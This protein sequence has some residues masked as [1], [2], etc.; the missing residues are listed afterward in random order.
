MILGLVIGGVAGWFARDAVPLARKR[1]ERGRTGPPAP[2]E[3]TPVIH[4]AKGEDGW[5]V[6][7]SGDEQPLATYPTKAD[8][9]SAGR[10]QAKQDGT[11]HVIHRV[12]DTVGER[13]D[14]SDPAPSP[15][16][17]AT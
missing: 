9:Q 14:Y 13:H 17:D 16:P 4:T 6:R 1:L 10:E 5:E 11:E 7:R 12:D 15:G 8:A 3:P 2:D